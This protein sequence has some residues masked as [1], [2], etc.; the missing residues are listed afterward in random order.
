MVV[1][2]KTKEKLVY[3]S[4]IDKWKILKTWDFVR[5]SFENFEDEWFIGR[6]L[7]NL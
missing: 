5:N 7:E 6:T 2:N 4:N 3:G 1:L